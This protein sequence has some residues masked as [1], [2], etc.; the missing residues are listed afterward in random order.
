MSDPLSACHIQIE[1]PV[2]WG[3]MD[4]FEHVNNVVYF[5]Y[6]ESA[7]IAYFERIGVNAYKR[8]HQVGPILA[9]TQCRFKA[10]LSYPDTITVGTRVVTMEADRFLMQYFVKSHQSS[11]IVAEGDG[12]IVYYDYAKQTKHTIPDEIQQ[13]ISELDQPADLPLNV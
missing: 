12:L 8:A 10:P 11:R 7:R 3:E 13:A 2:V 4:A 5:R 6:F 1:L 9:S